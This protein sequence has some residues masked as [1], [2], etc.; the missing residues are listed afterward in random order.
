MWTETMTSPERMGAVMRGEKPDRVPVIPFIFG[1]TALMC[2][3]PLARVYDDAAQSFRCQVLCQEMYGYD[4]GPLYAYASAGGWE[5]GG[6][7]EFPTKKY[8][9]APVVS[10]HP[11]QSEED[12]LALEVPGD[13]AHAGA[14]PI[15]LG[16]SRLQAEAGMPVTLQVGSPFTWAGSVI[17]EDRMMTWLLRK[18]DLVHRVLDKVS[19][20]AVKVAEHYAREFGAENL[21]AFHGAATE[22]NKL[23]SPRQFESFVLPYYQRINERVLGLGVSSMFIHICGEQNRNLEYW[24]RVP[25]PERAILS[26]GREVSLRTAMD[27]FPAQII[28]GN[29]DPTLIQEGEPEEV[30]AQ[31]RECIETAKDHQGGYVLMAGCDVPPLAPPVNVFQLV[32]AAREYGR[33]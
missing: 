9:G 19:E 16:L 30:L 25:V 24:Q 17:G 21:M 2:G 28:A 15:A 22:S 26:F 6:E 23:I 20:F 11:V 1:H 3:Q 10:R 4:G 32:K 18:P 8:S 13:V 31:A 27:M 12:A 5:F 29:V 14:L 33:Y 7:V